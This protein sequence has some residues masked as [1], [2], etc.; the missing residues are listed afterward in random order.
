VSRLAKIEQKM[1]AEEKAASAPSF[2]FEPLK[3]GTVETEPIKFD[4]LFQTVDWLKI[5]ES[6]KKEQ[7]KKEQ[8]KK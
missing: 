1:F 3:L 4:K 2:T 5:G 7:E 6:I 8:P